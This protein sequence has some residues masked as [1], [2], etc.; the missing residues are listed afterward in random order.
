M[1][2]QKCKYI[3]MFIVMECQTV[4]GNTEGTARPLKEETGLLKKRFMHSGEGGNC[5]KL[6]P[7][8]SLIVLGIS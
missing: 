6:T 2:I 1:L 7:C 5:K 8:N 4:L 3:V